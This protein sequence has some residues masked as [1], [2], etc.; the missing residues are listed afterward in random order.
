M[1]NKKISPCC[2]VPVVLLSSTNT[3]I[4][5]S[6]AKEHPWKLK[7]GVKSIL[8]ERVGQKEL[9]KEL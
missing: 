1:N 5:C 6:C 4:C 8:T 3:K 7:E 2:N 9:T